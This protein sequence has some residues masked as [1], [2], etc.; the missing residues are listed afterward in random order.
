M[1]CLLG[2]IFNFA[3]IELPELFITYWTYFKGAYVVVGMMVLGAALSGLRH[4]E[5]SFRFNALVFLGKFIIWPLVAF[6]FVLLDQHVM[7]LFSKDIHLM[8]ILLGLM[9]PGA[10]ITAY[11]AQFNVEPEKAATTVLAGTVFALFAIPTA[12]WLMGG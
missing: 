8:M 9:P 1:P 7:H 2:L 11:A 12:I 10:N 5:F 4:I 3:N 6:L